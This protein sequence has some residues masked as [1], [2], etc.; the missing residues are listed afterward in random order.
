MELQRNGRKEGREGGREKEKKKRE[1]N[2]KMPLASMY[3]IKKH[4]C[5]PLNQENGSSFLS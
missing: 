2:K 5:I 1:G 4:L 3:S